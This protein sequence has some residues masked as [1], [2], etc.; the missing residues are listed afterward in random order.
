MTAEVPAPIIAR[1]RSI[2]LALPDAQQEDAW[3]GTRWRVRRKTFA[4]VLAVENGWPPAYA[5][6]AGSDG[7]ML[8]L[9]FR[10]SGP[11]L[12]ALS[13]SGHPFFKPVWFPDIVGMVLDDES[14]WEEVA[15]LLTES[16]CVLAP[17]ALVAMVDRP[18]AST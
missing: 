11:E 15:E 8:T 14:D 17:S 4:H 9:T 12:E 18:A 2:C 10:S 16:Y 5:R 1:L 7:P 13:A 6:A 3:V